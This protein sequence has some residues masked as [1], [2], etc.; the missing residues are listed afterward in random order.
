MTKRLA[1]LLHHDA[2][3][4]ELGLDPRPVDDARLDDVVEL[5]DDES[6][7]E[8]AVQMM[9]ERRHAQTVDPVAIHCN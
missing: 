1:Y 2:Q 8:V 6:V 5:E 3:A 7:G 9:N 4:V